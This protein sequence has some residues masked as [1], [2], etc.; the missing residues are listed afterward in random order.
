MIKKKKAVE[1]EVVETPAPK[2][3][4]EKKAK[5]RAGDAANK[6]TAQLVYEL[7]KKDKKI[8]FSHDVIFDPNAP[9]VT[10]TDWVAMPAPWQKLT[11][12]KGVPFGQVTTIQ[13]KPDSGKT[14]IAMHAMVEAQEQGYNVVLIDTEDKFNKQRLVNMGGRI[15]D[16]TFATCDSVEEGFD[17]IEK[18]LEVFPKINKAPILFVWDSLGGTPTEEELKGTSRSFTVASAAKV[19]K[20]N[21]RR[22][23]SRITKANASVLFINHVY[24]NINALFG[25][26]TKG[27]G[28]NGAYFAAALCLEVQRI[29]NKEK[30]VG[31]V[32]KVIGIISGLKCTKNHLSDVQGGKAQVLIGPCGIDTQSVADLNDDD[33]ESIAAAVEDD[34]DDDVPAFKPKKNGRELEL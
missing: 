32:K 31:G 34:D 29:R 12:V 30:Q 1:A 7:L 18:Y 21:L 22:L 3:K 8:T 11:G 28:G 33:I 14:T 2:P 20:K 17:A 6:T 9:L 16:I 13:G 27:Y 24:D 19:I 23:R 25:N 4:A 15:D 26:S 10:A 5:P